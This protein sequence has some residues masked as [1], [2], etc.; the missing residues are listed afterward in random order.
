[1]CKHVAATMYGVGH[2]LDR[3]PELL[4]VLRGV[5]PLE[6]LANPVTVG[7]AAGEDGLDADG[8]GDLFGIEMDLD[9]ASMPALP[10]VAAAAKKKTASKARKKK[11]RV[12]APARRKA[13]LGVHNP[14]SITLSNPPTG[15]QISRL[16]EHLN[17]S[18]AAFARALGVTPASVHRW[19]AAPGTLILRARPYAAL[20][21]M[22]GQPLPT[23]KAHS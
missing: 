13:K 4:F 21:A 9:G 18:V 16:R 19:E 2:R 12:A 3:D 15:P 7:G 5:D 10:Q 23:R 22:L 1:M 11:A 20:R 6:L 14:V 8:L 17:M